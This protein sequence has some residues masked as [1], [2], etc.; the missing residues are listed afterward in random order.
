VLG[1]SFQPVHSPA[2]AFP[3]QLPLSS[4]SPTIFET[5]GWSRDFFVALAEPN[6]WSCNWTSQGLAGRA[7]TAQPQRLTRVGAG[8]TSH[9]TITTTTSST[10][11]TTTTTTPVGATGVGVVTTTSTA[12]AP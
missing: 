3:V 11:T 8:C 9:R 2:G 4:H 1:A 6:S 5:G 7:G 12:S 10:T